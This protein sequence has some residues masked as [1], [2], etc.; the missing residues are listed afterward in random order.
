MWLVSTEMKILFWICKDVEVEILILNRENVAHSSTF[1]LSACMY[2]THKL[3][4]LGL[5]RYDMIFV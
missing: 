1:F 3:S 2:H 4:V 5:C